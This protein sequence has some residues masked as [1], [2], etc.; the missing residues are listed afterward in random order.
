MVGKQSVRLE[1]KQGTI[2][3]SND[4]SKRFGSFYCNLLSLILIKY[5]T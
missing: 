5:E 3:G 2:S 1:D 4:V